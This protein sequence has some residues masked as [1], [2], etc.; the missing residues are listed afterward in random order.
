MSKS[1]NIRQAGPPKRS[2]TIASIYLADVERIT[3]YFEMKPKDGAHLF[4]ADET[5]DMFQFDVMKMC[6]IIVDTRLACAVF[7][8]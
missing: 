8:V 3:I 2:R 1:L 5:H 7:Q 4:W 6:F